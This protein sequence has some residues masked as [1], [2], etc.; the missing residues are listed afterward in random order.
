MKIVDVCAFYSP[1][2]GGVR[3]YIERKLVEGPRLGHEIVILAPGPEARVDHRGPNAR[4]VTIAARAFPLD[5]NYHYFDDEQA[6]LDAID[7]E[8]PDFLEAS[9]PW[10]SSEIVAKWPGSA[11]RALVMHAD[12]LAA[13]A[14]RWFGAIASRETINRHFQ[15]FWNHLRKLDGAFDFVVG[16]NAELSARLTAGGLR[17]VTTVPMGVEENLFSP[18]LRDEA[19]RS[20]LLAR[21]ALPTDATLLLGVGRHAP[22]KRWALVIEAAM[23]AAC[24]TPVG[25][26]LVGDGRE[27]E[28]LSRLIGT[29]PHI[30]LMPAIDDRLALARLMASVDALIH[31]CEAETFCMVA[32]EALASG[33]PVIVPDQGGASDHGRRGSGIVYHSASAAA[34][35]DAILDMTAG[36][37]LF[38]A[39]A[40]DGAAAARTI[41][42][43]FRDLFALYESRVRTMSRAA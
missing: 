10:R 35:A 34:A 29:N 21:C 1:N 41:A 20:A 22:E 33:T 19:L 40:R 14:Y 28:K 30:R 16:A 6:L 32:A 8:Q 13:Y 17:H 31:G 39:R 3:T 43:H 4:I 5:R 26:I 15:W 42:T 38:R 36:L 12:P 18:A 25:L 11:P 27:R 9:S 37:D 24:R 23:S 2:G 7:A